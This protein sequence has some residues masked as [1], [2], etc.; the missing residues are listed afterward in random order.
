MA[1]AGAGLGVGLRLT[2][3][4]DAPDPALLARLERWKTLAPELVRGHHLQG[5]KRPE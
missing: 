5:P 2:T 4:I 3:P 1:L